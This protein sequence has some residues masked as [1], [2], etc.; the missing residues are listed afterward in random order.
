MRTVEPP[1]SLRAYVSSEKS[2]LA[3]NSG[4][5]IIEAR[6][7]PASYDGVWCPD[8]AGHELAGRQIA[9][10][11]CWAQDDPHFAFL[12]P[13]D[14]PWLAPQE[15]E[16]IN[17]PHRGG[18]LTR[19]AAM[20]SYDAAY[21]DA[22]EANCNRALARLE[23]GRARHLSPRDAF[24]CGRGGWLPDAAPLP[25]LP[26]PFWSFIIEAIRERQAARGRKD[27]VLADAI[28]RECAAGMVELVD[29][30][31]GTEWIVAVE[32]GSPLP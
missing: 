7:G 24:V 26:P 25:S 21:L 28:R 31:G 4:W 8:D 22:I 3:P 2:R 32:Q 10:E 27:W 11:V 1:Q 30:K 14:H 18:H 19:M 23:I 5:R 15:V 20:T 17:A 9:T 13:S 6:N 12:A 16:H 29:Q